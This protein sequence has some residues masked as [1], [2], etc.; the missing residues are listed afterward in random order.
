MF[1]QHNGGAMHNPARS[2]C[3]LILIFWLA[4][5]GSPASG[6]TAGAADA[7]ASAPN[8]PT[9]TNGSGAQPGP[10]SA[11]AAPSGSVEGELTVF[12][13]ASLTEAFTE[14]GQRFDAAHNTRTTFNFAGSQQLARQIVQ[15][16]PADVFASANQT[17]MNNVIAEGYVVSG[18]QRTF[19]RNRLV[20]VYPI[21][22]PANIATLADLARPGVKLVLADQAVPVGQY[23]LDVLQ[24]AAARPTYGATF[25]EQVLA[26]VV[27]YEANVRA[28]LSKVTLGEADAGIVYTSDVGRDTERVGRLDIPDQLNSIATYPIA[29]V[30][31]AAHPA[32]ARAFIAYVLSPEGQQTLAAYGFTSPQQ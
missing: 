23:A 21:D 18:T 32:A 26:N 7:P 27:S 4:A 12:A 10:G 15:G 31:D 28:V 1:V 17:Q 6:S 11:G 29:P 5:C 14:L 20:I 16:A 8:S 25:R 2:L 19:V 30:K 22:N 24:K 3:V 9:T 13:A